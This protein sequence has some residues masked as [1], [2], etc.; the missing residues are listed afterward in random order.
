MAL[1]QITIIIYHTIALSCLWY[2]NAQEVNTIKHIVVIGVDGMSPDGIKNAHTPTMDNMITNGAHTF[3]ARAVLPTS[4]GPNWASMIMGADTEQHGVTSNSWNSNNYK[5]PAVTSVVDNLF[6]SIFD[7]IKQQKP[8]AT[9]GAV[10]D[11]GKFGRYLNTKVLNFN[12]DGDHEDGT[13]REAIKS[14]KQY[15]P[16]FTFIHLDHV[17]H[18]G[19]SR[20]HGSDA[21][22]KSV[23]K[24]DR[25]IQDI[26]QAT[27]D[28]GFFNDTMF[29]VSS[30]HGGRGFSHGGE[31]LS[32]IEIPFIMY[33]AGIK[34]GY[35]IDET[36]YQYDNAATV[37]FAFNLQLPQSWIGRAVKGAFI[38]QEKPKLTYK[39]QVYMFKPIIYPE[40]DTFTFSGGIYKNNA[41][42]KIKNPNAKGD[43]Y[44]TLD[45]TTPTKTALKYT[46]AFNVNKTTVVKAAVFVNGELKGNVATAYYRVYNGDDN[47]GLLYKQYA[48][49]KIKR[50]QNFKKQTPIAEGKSLEFNADILNTATLKEKTAL[51]FEGYINIE[52]SG[53]YTFYT[54]SDEDSML[55][56]NDDLVVNNNG[57]YN[58]H[59]RGGNITLQ[60]G[61][62]PI[63]LAYFNGSGFYHLTV[64]YQGPNVPK[65]IV[66]IDKL[67]I[68]KF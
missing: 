5:L 67:F 30:D 9:I 39:P 20:G 59:E 50:L 54:A 18:A 34:K 17:D 14:L 38:G 32:Q 23:E 28:A 57:K 63:K 26:V 27:K 48:S 3:R 62:H 25:L 10:Y 33:G 13:T 16:E 29:I 35:T 2:G 11:W 19:H 8:N 49:E 65:Q 53:A 45:G 22:Y 60:A 56:I 44:Y 24:A 58:V 12:I 36:V 42:V 15:K 1:K 66:S 68:S 40:N 7:V 52:K 46:K 21:Y 4:S 37:A 43:V 47:S 64:S 55:Y 41:T 6:P 61:L 51:V 31:T